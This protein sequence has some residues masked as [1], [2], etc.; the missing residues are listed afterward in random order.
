MSCDQPDGAVGGQWR[1]G[2]GI[3]V[4][5]EVQDTERGKLA[6]QTFNKKTKGQ[7]YSSEVVSATGGSV[8]AMIPSSHLSEL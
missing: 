6:R 4:H 1:P 3:L 8:D 5:H 7:S 2:G